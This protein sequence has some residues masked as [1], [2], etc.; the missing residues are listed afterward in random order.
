MQVRLCKSRL[1]RAGEPA[2][3]L[4]AALRE[5]EHTPIIADCLDRCTACEAGQWVATADG[6][7]IVA[8]SL[9]ALLALLDQLA[10]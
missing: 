7:P 3:A 8:P 10:E 2:R 5:R 9:P 4:I 6:M 1:M